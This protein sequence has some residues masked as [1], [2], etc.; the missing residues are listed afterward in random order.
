MEVKELRPY[1]YCLGVV[2]ALKL[3]EEVK[4]K[5]LD[6]SIYVFGM[7]VH[8]ND[9]V[10]S[11]NEKG[12]ITIDTTKI[13]KIERLKKFTQNDVVVFTAHGH[14][15]KWDEILKNNGVIYYDASCSIV[16]K[17]MSLIR[18]NLSS[19][20]VIYIGKKNHPETEAN[21]TLS[22]NVVLYD[23]KEGIDYTKITVDNPFVTNQTTLSI[24]E[25]QEIHND[26]KNHYKNARFVDE[27]CSST[28]IRQENIINEKEEYDLVVI[29]GSVHSSNTEKLYQIAKSRFK[30]S[31]IIKV[32]NL[33]D[34]KKYDLSKYHTALITSGTSTPLESIIGIRDYLRGIK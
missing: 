3:I 31:L 12:I 17:N 30:D 13:D 32:E 24:L 22:T 20:Q 11:L 16:L 1:G 7:L 26:I 29:I 8:N 6:K 25:L 33:E 14:N 19:S 9:V 23:I 15:Q 4:K 5:H 10:K 28:R 21:L 2:N 18:D 34:I 27:I